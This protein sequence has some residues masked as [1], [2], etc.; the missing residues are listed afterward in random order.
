MD[1]A[2]LIALK[3]EFNIFFQT[4]QERYTPI[5]DIIESCYYYRFEHIGA[6]SGKRYQCITTFIGDMGLIRTSIV[7]Q[8]L[9][10]RWQPRTFILL[11]IAAGLSKDVQI[12]D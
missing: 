12:G 10:H 1:I 11:G 5:T 7:T 9:I 2:I 8:Q 4:I 6:V 3:E